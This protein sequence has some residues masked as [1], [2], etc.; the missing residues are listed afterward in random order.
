MALRPELL[1]ALLVL[2]PLL[3]SAFALVIPA[4]DRLTL[5]AVGVVTG[6]LTLIPAFALLATP[7]ASL[8]LPFLAG[9]VSLRFA[10]VAIPAALAIVGITPM[11]LRAGAPRVARGLQP[12]V[13][14]ILLAESGA[15][16][17]VL[18]D[19]VVTAT[20][21]AMV[22]AVPFFALVA[23]FGGPERGSVTSRAAG[24]WLL[25]DAAAL[26]ALV[27]VQGAPAASV[28]PVVVV[29]LLGPGLVRLAAGP[30]GLWALPLIEQAP[31]AAACLM[32][33]LVAPVGA[34][35]LTRA[36]AV[37]DPGSL[38]VLVPSV[39][40]VLAVACA[41][42]GALVVAER[43]LRR[44]VAHLLGALGATTAL[45]AICGPRPL[46]AVGL[47]ALTGFL[48]AL[49]LM[50][51]EAVERRLETR[52]TTELVGLLLLAPS[53]GL[54][55]PLSLLALCGLPGPGLGRALWPPLLGLMGQGAET[56]AAAVVC[57]ASLLLAS[58][59][60]SGLLLRVG[61]VPR[62]RL[63]QMVSVSLQQGIRLLLPLAAAVAAV[64][65]HGAVM[66]VAS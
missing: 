26:G 34:V 20:A 28:H 52:R 43:D 42:G 27:I 14:A 50:L 45:I 31:V 60:A 61:G 56:G 40:G 59:G 58:V 62:K 22:A 54:L 1:V 29:A 8:P 4:D 37:I 65:A 30:H 35:L 10:G 66:R 5:R 64:A 32:G 15:L 44:M 18:V 63:R 23:L 49:C 7:G 36:L 21:A 13:T 53:L 11:A 19:D 38:A 48:A 24:L 12:Y 17:V 47:A 25:V 16:F 2:M 46:D 41:V 51:V 33:G 3:G 57:G 55:L 6:L 39:A 9:S